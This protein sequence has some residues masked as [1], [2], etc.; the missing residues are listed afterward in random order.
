[1][2]V[3]GVLLLSLAISSLGVIKAVALGERVEQLEMSVRLV[4]DIREQIRLERRDAGQILAAV[5][6]RYPRVRWLDGDRAGGD[7]AEIGAAF[8]AGL[9]RSDTDGQLSHCDICIADLSRLLIPARRARDEKSRL[10]V[11][12]GAA[13]GA[14]VFILLI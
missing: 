3:L 1:M 12:L 4:R 13:A 9:G 14:A 5:R 6:R 7:V 11:A 10:C 8:I 2:R